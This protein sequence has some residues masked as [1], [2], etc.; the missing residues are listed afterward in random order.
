M[1]DACARVSA[2]AAA[3]VALIAGA[4]IIVTSSVLISPDA[5]LSL[6][7]PVSP[8]A[9]V[10]DVTG[11][12]WAVLSVSA[13][14]SGFEGGS[15]VEGW[16]AMGCAEDEPAKAFVAAVGAEVVAAVCCC[17]GAEFDEGDVVVGRGAAS[18]ATAAAGTETPPPLELDCGSNDAFCSPTIAG[19]SASEVPGSCAGFCAASVSIEMIAASGLSGGA[20]SCCAAA[21]TG[22]GVI[23]AAGAVATAAGAFA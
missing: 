14:A 2:T 21:V 6:D 3:V 9:F 12:C 7:S 20:S 17:A 8:E 1:A 19:V 23:A 16:L 18:T 22:R 11:R 15:E 5:G 10:V 13:L 4:S